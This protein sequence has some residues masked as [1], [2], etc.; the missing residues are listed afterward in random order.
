[1]NAPSVRPINNCT[2]LITNIYLFENLN[3]SLLQSSTINN[4]C[5]PLSNRIPKR[6]SRLTQSFQAKHPSRRTT[7]FKKQQTVATNEHQQHVVVVENEVVFQQLLKECTTKT[8]RMV[9]EKMEDFVEGSTQI[10]NID[11]S[12]MVNLEENV[13]IAGF[14]DLLERIWSH[15]LH[16]K[17]SGKSALWNHIKCYIKLNNYESA[18][19][20]HVDLPIILKKDENPGQFILF[21]FLELFFLFFLFSVSM[22][23]RKKTIS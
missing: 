12:S 3:G 20:S 2:S 14:C 17:P 9:I 15:G 23:F 13:L 10:K 6:N 22:V 5:S 4:L 19:I 7:R 8:K 18:H 1:M 21:F 16:H 11:S